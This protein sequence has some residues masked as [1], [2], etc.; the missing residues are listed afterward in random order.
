MAPQQLGQV[1]KSLYYIRCRFEAGAFDAPP[2][3][4][5][6]VFNAA[7]AEQSVPVTARWIIEPGVIT[8]GAEPQPG[9]TVGFTL[10]L[11]E[12][13]HITALRFQP[14][15]E[16]V[17]GF[18][19]LEYTK[20]SSK[21]SGSLSVAAVRLGCS[22][23]WPNQEIELP[24]APAVQSSFALYTDEA[25]LWRSWSRVGDFVHSTRRDTHFAFDPS[26]GKIRFGDGEKGRVPPEAA[27]VFAV[28]HATR[29]ENGNL[30][31]GTSFKLVDSSLNRIL[32][33]DF[34]AV[35]ADLKGVTNAIPSGG[36]A[37]AEALD[38]AIGRAID[39]MH[40]Q[41]R[42]VTLTDYEELAR[43]TPGARIARAAARANLHP[44]F[45]CFL[46]P[47]M[48]TLI[49]L[50]EQPGTRP[51][52][53]RGLLRDVASYLHQR[54]V[55]GT[56]VEVVGPRYREVSVRAAVKSLDGVSKANLQQKINA[57]L[58]DFFDPLKGGPDRT[59]WPF[60]R[61][62]YRTEVLQVIDEVV[63]VDNVSKLELIAEDCAPQCGN[64]C[65]APTWL[66]AS[67]NH[68]IEVI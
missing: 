45:P 14:A 47:G 68:E 3:A 58:N 36:G 42:A 8:Q 63:G 46:A 49:V 37:A 6:V 40:S 51:V 33:K 21:S 48:V 16:Q 64:V 52:P 26:S 10:G 57:A 35:K 55:I 23:G 34:D 28:Y 67:G 19:V 65:L 41:W 15:S 11:D 2:I 32:V 5:G 22:T 9:N 54:R 50:P 7:V 17:P 4:S 25:D 27:K 1:N 66:V 13:G 43:K 18:T 29:A 60:G 61:D 20:A 30:A 31:A 38:H 59:G 44:N 53:G 24:A 56:R 62:V 39:L 12:R